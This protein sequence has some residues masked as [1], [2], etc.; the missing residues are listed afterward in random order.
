M[1][2]HFL[3][4]FNISSNIF[5]SSVS[6]YCFT[7]TP[8][9]N[10]LFTLLAGA[11]LTTGIFSILL[12]FSEFMNYVTYKLR[13][14]IMERTYIKTLSSPEQDKLKT[15]LDEIVTNWHRN[16]IDD[17]NEEMLSYKKSAYEQM[18]EADQYYRKHG[19][20][21]DLISRLLSKVSEKYPRNI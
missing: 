9:V 15:D 3:G 1:L 5:S 4:F 14:I 7:S 13:E 20:K 21:N 17:L 11:F 10:K 12:G 2:S 6:I 16:C 18:M 19:L 8:I